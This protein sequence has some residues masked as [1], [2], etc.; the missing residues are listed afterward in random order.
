L[1]VTWCAGDRCDMMGSNEDHGMSRRPGA[2]D[3]RWSSIGRVLGGRM[4]ERSGDAMCGLHRIQGDEER[5]FLGLDS[6]PR[7]TVCQWFVLK[8]S[9]SG[10]SVWASELAATVW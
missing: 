6:K 10:F 3:R 7:S 1:L 8:T 9:G 2:E 4:V 5:G